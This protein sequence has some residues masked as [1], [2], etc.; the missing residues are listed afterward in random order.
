MKKILFIIFFLSSVLTSQ[1]Y[2]SGYLRYA[3]ASFC[4]SQCSEYYLVDEENIYIDNFTLGDDN[5]ILAAYQDRFVEIETTGTVECVE[6]SAQF[7]SSIN[8]FILPQT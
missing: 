1:D 4:M 3:E 2:Y 8:I 7:I 5:T 6:C